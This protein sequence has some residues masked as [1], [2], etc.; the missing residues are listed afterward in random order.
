MN[1]FIDIET[2]PEQPEKESRD[3][4]AK[5]IS[6]PTAM[7]KQE[8]I[9]DWHNGAGKYVGEKEAAIELEYLKTSLT[10]TKGQV[11]SISFA[12]GDGEIMSSTDRGN[13]EYGLLKWFCDAINIE[14][15]INGSGKRQP[16]FV[17]HYVGGFDLKFLFQRFVINQINP[18]IDLPFNGRHGQSFYDTMTAW[19]G[20]KERISQ[21]SLCEALG[22]KGK[23]SDIDGSMVWEY[24]KL[25]EMEKIEEYNRN[26]VAKVREIYKRLT[27]TGL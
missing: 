4:I 14:L 11:C 17:G 2:I 13:G 25:G 19:S 9:Q 7:K 3:R 15:N 5:A 22:I 23:P 8:T 16:F 27:F 1:V 21:N 26:D 20:Y 10:G 24:Y 12:V 18:S 6:A